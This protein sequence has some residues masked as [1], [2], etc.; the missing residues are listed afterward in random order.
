MGWPGR[1]VQESFQNLLCGNDLVGQVERNQS[2]FRGEYG[3]GEDGLSSFGV[4]LGLKRQFLFCARRIGI[5]KR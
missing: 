4:T 3:V 5:K 2:R 1:S